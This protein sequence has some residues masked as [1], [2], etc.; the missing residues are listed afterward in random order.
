MGVLDLDLP[1]YRVKKG[2][3]AQA[4]RAEPDGRF[5]G[6]DWDRLCLQ[7]EKM[8]RRTPDSFV[9]VYSI[10]EGIR[11][12]PAISILGLESGNVFD[13]YRPQNIKLF[14]K[15]HLECYIGDPRLNSTNIE[16]LDAL[17]DLRVERVFRTGREII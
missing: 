17:A 13:L 8:L 11:I 4:K 16:T 2:F 9:F 5:S 15:S 14:S 1:D 7:C 12:F 6:R 10:S 3:L